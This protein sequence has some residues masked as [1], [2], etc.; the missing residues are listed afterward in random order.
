MD[1]RKKMKAK[2]AAGTALLLGRFKFVCGCAIPLNFGVAI[3]K[4]I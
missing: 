2:A 3:L 4:P 1:K